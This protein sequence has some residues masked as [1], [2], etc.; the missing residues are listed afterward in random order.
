MFY[1]KGFFCGVGAT[2]PPVLGLELF[3]LNCQLFISIGDD[4]GK[5]PVDI[6]GLGAANVPAGWNTLLD[7]NTPVLELGIEL[8]IN[9]HFYAIRN[10]L[11]NKV[12][13]ILNQIYAIRFYSIKTK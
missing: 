9:K 4:E 11:N 1:K 6:N 12:I 13:F 8:Y 2:Y 10:L 7:G 3:I 5:A